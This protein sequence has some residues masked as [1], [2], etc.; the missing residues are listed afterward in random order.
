MQVMRVFKGD[1]MV[2]VVI[3]D[4]VEVITVLEGAF[5]MVLKLLRFSK[6]VS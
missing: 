3:R 5:M 4:Y 2:V 1:F 6:V